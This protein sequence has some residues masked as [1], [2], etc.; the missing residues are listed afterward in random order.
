MDLTVMAYILIA[1]IDR[2]G[3]VTVS[4]S[5]VKVLENW[6]PKNKF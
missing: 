6:Q 3:G 5:V 1:N 4:A 2:K